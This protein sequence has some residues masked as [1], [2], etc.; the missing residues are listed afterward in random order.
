MHWTHTLQIWTGLCFR[1]LRIYEQ[2]VHYLEG[3]MCKRLPTPGNETL[4]GG[5]NICP[6]KQKQ[7]LII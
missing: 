3:I 1:L 6:I 7:N 2:T 4:K 5:A